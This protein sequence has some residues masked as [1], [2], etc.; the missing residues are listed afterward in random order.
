MNNHHNCNITIN[1][2]L[3]LLILIA[4][5]CHC[6]LV[7]NYTNVAQVHPIDSNHY[8]VTL[9]REII[10][11]A[12]YNKKNITSTFDSTSAFTVQMDPYKVIDMK[13]GKCI[14]QK[15]ITS[16]Y[17]SNS[18]LNSIYMFH[19]EDEVD[20]SNKRFVLQNCHNSKCDTVMDKMVKSSFSINRRALSLIDVDDHSFSL[21]VI[22]FD[23]STSELQFKL[24]TIDL[25]NSK[26]YKESIISSY[27]ND[28]SQNSDYREMNI[29]HLHVSHNNIFGHYTML[30]SIGRWN[31][32]T[33]TFSMME[34]LTLHRCS[35]S[36][37]CS[38]HIQIDN[39]AMG[40][41]TAV[42]PKG[43]E[44]VAYWKWNNINVDIMVR[45]CLPSLHSC[46]ESIKLSSFVSTN[47][48]NIQHP[49]VTALNNGQIAIAWISHNSIQV[50]K[51]TEQ[52]VCSKIF[53]STSDNFEL[54]NL[55]PTKENSILLSLSHPM[56][57]VVTFRID[58]N[59]VDIKHI[60]SEN[61]CKSC[62]FHN[63]FVKSH[64]KLIAV[65]TS[66]VVVFAILVILGSVLYYRQNKHSN[67]RRY[68]NLA[69]SE[70]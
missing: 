13:I 54:L 23:G 38:E 12:C 32:E 19:I 43:D 69:L 22:G 20:P 24:Q 18:D 8:I 5:V 58:Q 39:N 2:L 55:F 47:P 4:T 56:N 27:P 66:L 36:L 14:L 52:I 30:S 7:S 3:L 34:Y 67:T 49:R 33:N 53:E 63:S 31:A 11:E 16:T 61:I 60:R 68:E 21:A 6:D 40:G 59:E 10:T 28:S 48:Q 64:L 17:V 26:V 45:K 51:C 15:S 50:Y 57:G 44:V 70:P 41:S 25:N 46:G 37:V 29:P 62:A 42:L 65:V 1:N 35:N 9:S